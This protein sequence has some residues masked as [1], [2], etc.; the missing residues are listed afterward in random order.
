MF[1]NYYKQRQA[2]SNQKAFGW[3]VLTATA[4][5]LVGFLSHKA[6]RDKIK[7]AV[8]AT[9]TTVEKKVDGID[10]ENIKTEGG[11]KIKQGVDFVKSKTEEGINFAESQI[12]I[13]DKFSDIMNSNQPK[14]VSVKPKSAQD[15]AK[16]VEKKAQEFANGFNINP[17]TVK[18]DEVEF[19][20][21][22]IK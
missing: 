18:D 12:A 6:N 22:E 15:I 13:Q 16:S 20:E 19:V 14:T 11:S 21:G 8:E 4:V 10:F 2:Q 1:Y 7:K 5:G 9:K 17:N 3:S